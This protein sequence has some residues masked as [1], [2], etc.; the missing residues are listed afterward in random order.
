V[1]YPCPLVIESGGAIYI[2]NDALKVPFNYQRT[3]KEYKIIELGLE[4]DLI[5][6]KIRSTTH[7]GKF[8]IRTFSDIIPDEITAQSQLLHADFLAAQT[9]RY[10]EQIL[11]EEGIENLE[12]FEKAMTGEQLRIHTR[13]SGLLITGDHDAGSAVRFLFQLY[14]EEYSPREIV[15][16]GLGD[17]L[18]DAAMLHAVDLP[19]LLRSSDGQFDSRIGRR[20][21]RF[22]KNPGHLGWGQAV[23]SLIN[24]QLES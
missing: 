5:K 1:G 16:I 8:K 21:L 9:R 13:D 18:H 7:D 20:G 19:V 17:G 2:P 15:T 3:F 12:E 14:R 23:A 6:E 22:T 24:E 11:L 10:S 4:R